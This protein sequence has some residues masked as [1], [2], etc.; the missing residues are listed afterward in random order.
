MIFKVNYFKNLTGSMLSLRRYVSRQGAGFRAS[1]NV[2]PRY[3][4]PREG[5]RG[6]L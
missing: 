4:D 1:F 3:V 2:Q 6:G 5:P